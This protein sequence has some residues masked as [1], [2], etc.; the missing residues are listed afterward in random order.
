M[1]NVKKIIS[2]I[3]SI[4][5]SI[6]LLAIYLIISIKFTVLSKGNVQK[7]I[8]KTN[9]NEKMYEIITDSM[10]NYIMQSG[11]DE[12]ILNNVL[13]NQT[14]E[15]DTNNIIDVI[16]SNTELKISTNELQTN[17]EKN[18]QE[19]I[20]KNNFKVDSKTKKDIEKFKEKIIQTYSSNIEYSQKS[21]KK[22]SEYYGIIKIATTIA[23]VVCIIISIILLI[24]EFNIN[25]SAIGISFLSSGFVC[26]IAKFYTG[27]NVA[28]NNILV[29]NTAISELAISLVNQIIQYICI[30]G[31][32][33]III[34]IIVI[35]ISE[36]KSKK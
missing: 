31:I 14:I 18:I 29:L 8:L 28:I 15:T 10:K 13:T 24:I 27:I 11:F 22:I 23:L 20:T 16:Y 33:S 9:Y 36:I 3:I 21:I 19:H 1:I 5:L 4:I 34:G 30:T 7:Q 25:K 2:Y 6:F 17:I 32:I 26:I 35:V 12:T